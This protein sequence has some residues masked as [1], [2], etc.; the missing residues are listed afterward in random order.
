MKFKVPARNI[1]PILASKFGMK[2]TDEQLKSNEDVIRQNIMM[3]PSPDEESVALIKASTDDVDF[4]DEVVLPE[5][6]DT[7]QFMSNAP[8]CWSHDYNI[9][10]IGKGLA[11][12]LQGNDFYIKTKFAAG[13]TTFATEI[14]GLV[15]G[16]F[17]KG[18]SMGFFP[19]EKVLKGKKG[20]AELLQN[21]LAHLSEETRARVESIVTKSLLVELS[22]CNMGKNPSALV[23]AV[24]NKALTLSPDTLKALGMGQ[25]NN[26]MVTAEKGEPVRVKSIEELKEEM[27]AAG[28]SKNG[29]ETPKPIEHTDETSENEPNWNDMSGWNLP[30]EAHAFIGHPERQNTWK[31]AHHYMSGTKML[32]HKE[33]LKAACNNALYD[34]HKEALVHL[35]THVDALTKTVKKDEAVAPNVTENEPVVETV[36]IVE[37]VKPEVVEDKSVK[38]LADNEILRKGIT[39]VALNLED[40]K[41]Q[42]IRKA[43]GKVIE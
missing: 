34:V 8:I 10:A 26:V 6:I 16:G 27:E 39:I 38:I 12:S 35:F 33:G 36:A 41:K 2:F 21:R 19:L 9:P 29:V 31:F 28:V 18:A 1:L 40:Y 13:I 20:F 30:K 23:M 25:H 24:S 3:V 37:P 32:L 11:V 4:D 15:K 42:Q 22:I 14:W 43:I 7:T 17:V 5:G